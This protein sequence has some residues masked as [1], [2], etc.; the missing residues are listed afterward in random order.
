MKDLDNICLALNNNDEKN[1]YTISPEIVQTSSFKFKNFKHYLDVNAHGQFAYTYTRGQNPTTSLLEQ[2]MAQLEGGDDAISFA[3]GMGAISGTILSLIKKGD[4]I[5]IVNTVYGSS[6]KLIS[7]LSKFGVEST[8]IDVLE[9]EDIFDYLQDN[10]KMIYFESPSSQKF[11]LL[12]LERIAQ[13]AIERNIF[14]VIDNT[15]ATPLL[16]QPLKHG[17]DVVIH[18]CSKYIGGHSDLVGGV[19]IAKKPVIQMIRDFSV[20]YL[21][22]TMS[23]ANAW[24]AIRGL[25]TLPVR[26]KHLDQAVRKVIEFLQNDERI[27]KIYHPLC[28]SG[29]QKDLAEKYLSGMGSLLGIVLKDADENKIATFTDCLQHFTLAYSWGGFESLILPV[30]KGNNEEELKQRGLALGHMRMYIG[31]EEPELL[32]K[33]IAQALDQAYIKR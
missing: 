22:A 4:H 7:Y 18:S 8:K 24:L 33:D 23:P 19:A 21:G 12:D 15:W 25:R 1:Y 30:Y 6:V 3:S 11:E 14:T 32:I 10:T 29:Q 28:G 20:T 9:T 16:Q 17:I 13:A 26:M 31:L 27:E 2:K 5:L